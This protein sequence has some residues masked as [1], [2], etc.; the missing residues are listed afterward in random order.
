MISYYYYWQALNQAEESLKTVAAMQPD[1]P[2]MV[3]AQHEMNMLELDYFRE[4][5][6]KFT[7]KLLI[8]FGLCIIML[9]IYNKGFID[10]QKLMG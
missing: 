8:F 6:E 2:P 4:E 3:Q 5:A 1:V 10:V 7:K 9:L